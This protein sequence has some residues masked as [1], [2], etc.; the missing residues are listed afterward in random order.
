MVITGVAARVPERVDA[1][2]YIDA[3]VPSDGDSTYDL[4]SNDLR[5]WY[6]EG[7][8]ADGYSVA[9]LPVFEPRATPH[10]LA[11]LLQQIRLTGS[12]E[13]FRRRDYVY[14]SGWQEE[15]PFAPVYERLRQDRSWNVHDLPTRHNFMA[16]ASEEVLEI[17]LQAGT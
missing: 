4:A 17:L 8:R 13:A 12:L 1:L 6:L 5:R 2:V 9:P 10:P 16:E 15:S 7:A 14:L 3:F 11:S